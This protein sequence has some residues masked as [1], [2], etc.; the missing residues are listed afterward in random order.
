[1]S[2]TQLRS[3]GILDGTISAGDLASGV[4]GKVLQVVSAT[5]ATGRTTTSTSY[6]TA[7]N[8]L[9]VTITPS[10]SSNKIFIILSTTGQGIGEIGYYTIFK[11]GVNLVGGN[12]LATTYDGA[13]GSYDAI[14]FNYLD[15]PSTTSATTY[16]LYFKSNNASNIVHINRIG[17]TA[18]ITVFEIAG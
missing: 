16:Q 11:N 18:S 14:C 4:R 15:S 13:T 5:D 9:S 6:V 2:L 1:M 7:S 8:T 12:G 10:S 3:R 17:H